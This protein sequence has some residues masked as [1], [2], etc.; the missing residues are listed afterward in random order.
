MTDDIKQ[1]E[2]DREIATTLDG[3][4]ITRGYTGPLLLA[5]DTILRT[6]G[7]GNLAIYDQIL[8]EPQ[9][10]ATFQQRRHAVTS[11][12]WRVE[13]ASDR[14]V[15]K[16]AAAALDAQLRNVGWDARTDRML[17][18]VY[19]GF[20]AAE[21]IWERQGALFGWKAIKVRDR[22]RFRFA[23]DGGLRLL[24]PHAMTEG[25]P[26][27]APYFWHYATGASH[28]DEPYGLGLA[29]WCYW[30]VLFKRNGVKFWLI[31]LEKFGSPTA[32]GKYDPG[33]SPSERARLLQA[34]RAIQTDSGVI[35]PKDMMIELLEASKSGTADYKALHDTMDETIAKVVLGQTM[36]SE[37]GSSKSQAEVHHD[38]RQDIVRADNDLICESFMMG[39]AT[40]FTRLN[41]PGADVPRVVRDIEEPEDLD[42]IAARDEKVLKLG[43]VPTLDYIHKTYGDGWQ[44]KTPAPEPIAAGSVAAQPAAPAAADFADG[45]QPDLADQLAAL[46]ASEAAAPMGDWLATIEAAVNA[47][48]S[49][50]ELLARLAQLQTELPL[51]QLGALL[52]TALGTAGLAGRDSVM[53]ETPVSDPKTAAG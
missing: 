45:D 21:L 9:V 17:F 5:Q 13:A 46:L 34:V 33:A 10:L 11:R 7:G 28:D 4:D 12:T 29:H 1:P 50:D 23:P 41:F 32:V 35:M 15:D 26:A 42:Q 18:G 30:P 51:D 48:Q 47:S 37:D 44:P 52:Q 40:W 43:F 36:T 25:V 24:L 6:R 8:S 49:Y 20:A 39:P 14:R 27:E 53:V 38:V 22:R 31:A 3:L 16:Q 2:L 19:Y